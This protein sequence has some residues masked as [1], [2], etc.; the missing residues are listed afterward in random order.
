M[1]NE[2]IACD[3]VYCEGWDPESG[4]VVHPLPEAVARARD[5]AGEQYAVALL[6]DERPIAL[7]EVCWAAHHAAAWLFD[8]EGRRDRLVEFRRFPTADG[9]GMLILR[10]IEQW[11]YQSPQ[12]LEFDAAAPTWSSEFSIDGERFDSSVDWDDQPVLE[13]AK[14]S[15]PVPAFGDWAALAHLEEILGAPV[16][17]T[18]RADPPPAPDLPVV[19]RP[20]HPPQPAEPRQLDE[21]FQAGTRFQLDDGAE[22]TVE[23]EDGG[24]LWLTTGE[25]IAADPDPWMHEIEPFVDTVEPGEYPLVLSI[26]RFADDP[27]HT[28]VAAGKLVVSDAETVSWGPALRPGEDVRMLGDSS[29]FTVGIDAGRLAIVDA[30]VAEAYEDIIEDAYDD[31]TGHVTSVP[32]PESGANLLAIHSG[33]GDGAYPVWVG[34]AED[35]SVTCFVFDFLVLRHA[36]QVG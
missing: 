9:E 12:Q 31:M 27:D 6:A 29:Y 32:E 28:R 10:V 35:G 36:K 4:S 19:E 26:A 7:I 17:L 5:D 20:W 11:A 13:I 25:L 23:I 33:W 3:V 14:T 18:V 1:T 2:T 16:T 8:G 15:G 21:I 30:D 22:L 34:R 24:K